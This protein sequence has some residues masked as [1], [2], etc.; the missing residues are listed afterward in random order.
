M[1]LFNPSRHFFVLVFLILF[2]TAM[3]PAWSKG[4]LRLVD[5][6]YVVPMAIAAFC[7]LPF[8][9]WWEGSTLYWRLRLELWGY[10]TGKLVS[11]VVLV[12]LIY[13]AWWVSGLA[14]LHLAG[15]GHLIFLLA[16]VGGGVLWLIEMLIDFIAFMLDL[17]RIMRDPGELRK[18]AAKRRSHHE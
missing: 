5:M 8:R 3:V 2:F 1:Q 16:M 9:T 7:V 13:G 15:T 4:Y 12:G 10:I 14:W 18:M 17:R 11:L 6:V